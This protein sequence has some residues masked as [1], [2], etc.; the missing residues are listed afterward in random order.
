MNTAAK[1]SIPLSYYI[2]LNGRCRYPFTHNLNTALTGM[3]RCPRCGHNYVR[4]VNA[5]IVLAFIHTHDPDYRAY[6]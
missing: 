3:V 6:R 2:C 4:W 1:T 5:M